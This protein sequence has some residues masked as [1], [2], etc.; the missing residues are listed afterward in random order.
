MKAT[1][2]VEV[3]GVGNNRV[4]PA[5]AYVVTIQDVEDD[6]RR[7]SLSIIYDVAEGE[8]KG[9]YADTPDEDSWK[10]RFYERYS[11]RAKGF[12]K[13][14]LVALEKS[15]PGFSIEQWQKASNEKDFIGKKVGVIFNNFH[16]VSERDGKERTRL[17]AKMA[18][19]AD[20]VRDGKWTM[21]EDR[22]QEGLTPHPETSTATTS[23]QESLYDSVPF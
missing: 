20:D 18:I 13:A 16:Y 8:Y 4:M 2:W 6:P 22:W 7:E 10:H 3:T 17:E 14:F 11:D 15:N 12:F 1:N 5:G 9:I 23:G 21:P 19:P